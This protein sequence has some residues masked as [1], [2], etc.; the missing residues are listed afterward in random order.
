VWSVSSR[1]DLAELLSDAEVQ[2][3][4]QS[5]EYGLKGLIGLGGWSSSGSFAA[6]RMTARIG[7]GQ[8]QGQ[9]TA[10]QAAAEQATAEQAT[11]EQATAEQAT[12]E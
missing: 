12:A 3:Q 8:E 4:V 2:G 11:A 7:N 10:E 6:L 5:P 9:A 1:R